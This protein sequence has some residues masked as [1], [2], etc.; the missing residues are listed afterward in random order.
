M[1]NVRL[2][3]QILNSKSTLLTIKAQTSFNK[4]IKKL[5]ERSFDFIIVEKPE[6]LQMTAILI[7]RLIGHKFFWIQNFE[8]PPIPTLITKILLNQA[9]RIVVENRANYIKVVKFGINKK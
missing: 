3:N 6:A 8:N 1:S 9:D 5:K 7:M 4:T 2:L